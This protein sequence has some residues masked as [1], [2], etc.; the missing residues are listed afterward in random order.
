MRIVS[1]YMKLAVL[2][3]VMVLVCGSCGEVVGN[4]KTDNAMDIS[5]INLNN[6]DNQIGEIFNNNCFP[7][8]ETTIHPPLIASIDNGGNL[9]VTNYIS[10]LY[11]NQKYDI[12]DS[13]KD[14]NLELNKEIQVFKVLIGGEK[15]YFSVDLITS[16]V[17][18]DR[19]ILN[20]FYKEYLASLPEPYNKMSSEL[21]TNIMTQC[22]SYDLN[23]TAACIPVIFFVNTTNELLLLENEVSKYTYNYTKYDGMAAK[24]VSTNLDLNEVLEIGKREY[25]IGIWLDE[26]LGDNPIMLNSSVPYI[27]A[28]NV[29]NNGI[30]GWN[31]LVGVIDT[32]VDSSHPNLPFVIAREDFT[33]ALLDG[34][35]WNPDDDGSDLANNGDGHGTHVAGIVGSSHSTY[36]GV[37]PFCDIIS[38]KVLSGGGNSGKYSTIIAGVD[39]SLNQGA[40]IIQMSIGGV[41]DDWAII[42]GNSQISKYFDYVS[43]E[44]GTLSVISAGN[45]GNAGDYPTDPNDGTGHITRPA[46]AYNV[47]SVGATDSNFDEKASYSSFGNT[48]DGRGAIEVMAPGTFIDSCNNNWET[49]S[50]FRSMSGTSMA[51]PHVSGV[52]ALLYDYSVKNGV[53]WSQELA[54]SIIM[55]SANKLSG[56]TNENNDPLD[57]IQGTGQIDALNSYNTY[58]D[59]NK[60][61]YHSFSSTSS[62]YYYKFNVPSTSTFSSTISWD[63]HITNY[64]S[65]PPSLND[66]DL[67]LYTIDGTQIKSS[68]SSIDNTE[69]LYYQNLAPGLY[70]VEVEPYS[71]PSGTEYVGVAFNHPYYYCGSNPGWDTTPPTNPTSYTSSHTPSV[72]S[73]DNTIWIQ[74]SGAS[75]ASGIQ[76]YSIDWTPSSSTIPDTTRD[77]TGTSTT[78]LPLANGNNWWFHV[79][80]VDNAE[81]WAVGAYHVGPFYITTSAPTYSNQQTVPSGTVYDT[82]SSNIKLQIDWSSTIGI[83][84]VKFHYKYGS[85]T[86]TGWI[87]PSGSSGST[88]WYNIPQSDWLN[89]IGSVVY[90]ESYATDLASSTAYSPTLTGP[91]L[92]D[93]DTSGPAFS[94]YLDDGN[95]DESDMTAYHVGV[96]VTDSSGVSSVQFAYKFG[97]GSWSSYFNPSGSSGSDYWYDIPRTTWITHVS[98]T[99]YWKVT[100]TDN[101][102]DRTGD[103]AT[104]TSPDQ[105]GGTI[106]DDDTTGPAYSNYLSD[107]NIEDSETTAYHIEVTVTDPN[108]VSSVQFAYSFGTGE[109][110]YVNPTGSSGDDYWYDIPRTTWITHVGETIYWKVTATDNDND[111]TGDQATSTSPDQTGGS[112]TDDDTNAPTPSSEVTVPETTIYDGN[113]SAIRIQLNWNDASGLGEVKF[114]YKYGA[115][116]TF[117]SWRVA[118]G[119][120][121][122]LYFYDIPRTE[123][124][125]HLGDSIYWESYAKDSDDDGWYSDSLDAYTGNYSGCQILDDD[126]S[127]PI[128]SSDGETSLY[129]LWVIAQDDSGWSLYVE[130]Y[131][132]DS[133]SVIHKLQGQTDCN[134]NANVSVAISEAELVPHIGETIHWRYM[135]IDQDNDREN[136][137]LN[138]T[139]TAWIISI[140]I[141]DS[142]PPTTTYVLTGTDGDN[143]WKISEVIIEF[144][145]S[146]LMSG[147][148]CTMYIIDGGQPVPYSSSFALDEDG[149][150]TI[151][152][153]S[154]D[155]AGN[156]E[157]VKTLNVKIDR[158][159]PTTRHDETGTIVSG[160]YTSNT[161]LILEG[162]EN[163]SEITEVKYRIN[164]QPGWQTYNES[165]D[166]TNAG[167]YTVEF[168]SVDMAGN[169]ETTNTIIIKIDGITPTIDI[170][171]PTDGM[172]I[173]NKTVIVSWAGQDEHSGIDHYEILIDNGTWVNVG[174][175]LSYVMDIVDGNHTIT[176]RAYD[177]AGNYIESS[178]SFSAKLPV[179]P[180]LSSFNWLWLL[181]LICVALL[182]AILLVKRRTKEE[183]AELFIRACPNCG[184]IVGGN[185]C[186][187]CGASVTAPFLP[188]PPKTC[189]KCGGTVEG[190]F[191]GDCGIPVDEPVSELII[192]TCPNCG[193]IVGGSFCGDCGQSM[194]KVEPELTIKTCPSCGG[195]VGGKFCGDCGL[196]VDRTDSD[197]M[198]NICPNCGG[199]VGGK[200]CGE[201]GTAMDMDRDISDHASKTCPKCGNP[202][203]G[204]FCGDCGVLAKEI[205]PEPEVNRC[206]KCGN[207]VGGKFCG[208]CGIPV[209][210]SPMGSET[211]LKVEHEPEME[212]NSQKPEG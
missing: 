82:S 127:M 92:A 128:A 15:K 182:V 27:D 30:D 63:R 32:G 44:M 157:S 6:F 205:T 50:D 10:T 1:G 143:G 9:A 59:Q 14:V 96:T 97:T 8:L 95:I 130:Y 21:R 122:T 197:L 83:S 76:G 17:Y 100:A 136:D 13:F 144:M 16:K 31:T 5:D 116:G 124:I 131:Y 101:D 146:D 156:I 176:I 133:P 22:N 139:W 36:S 78:S 56:W 147:F 200:F 99:I 173:T 153:Y 134:E 164:R 65:V 118:T 75:D 170:M 64:N 141:I 41:M 46:D 7:N 168:Y 191:C 68:I 161:T 110:T 37:A 39:W 89:H 94:N 209:D 35:S 26:K 103:Q 43:W 114:R 90:W 193:S 165:I 24:F 167:M 169:I 47:L 107:G 60:W 163:V 91:T 199:P 135:L 93:E 33:D 66:I 185:F 158:F 108:D 195:L 67:K 198:V 187:E 132:S 72:W 85:G 54:R 190:T 151:Q 120:N 189:P 40:D 112:I 18:E 4:Y 45:Y 51:A 121:G 140:T 177:V 73:T 62:S 142:I 162:I 208:D 48:F 20:T 53:I 188:S 206:P 137:P 149:N 174:A 207:A 166:F 79:R 2:G 23:N 102:N 211:K 126:I 55:N 11:P 212:L 98:E 113:S 49:Q 70:V 186:G 204:K 194:D 138:T 71:L 87:S 159:A 180:L 69:H 52:A 150:H 77:T 61:D 202:V 148:N 171:H 178:K 19:Y 58:L 12:I 119:F 80:A 203:E 88:Y 29:W 181:L 179:S 28:D 81:N 201:C 111:R 152:F 210:E 104:S 129:E 115:N 38:A 42:D 184:S 125:T 172:T 155:N 57:E 192:R 145:A 25:I 86:F 196:S 105:T 109:W 3:I 175:N 74:W 160:W 34:Y 123:W 117:T 84:T 183:P 154:M 106:T